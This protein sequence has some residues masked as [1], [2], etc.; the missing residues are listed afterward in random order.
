[1]EKN[2]FWHRQHLDRRPADP[3][4]VVAEL[5][6]I[7]T[8]YETTPP[9]ALAARLPDF[10]LKDFRESLS[11]G[12]LVW[13]SAMRGSKYVIH[14]SFANA[15]VSAFSPLAEELTW[16]GLESMG[17]RRDDVTRALDPVMKAL[18]AAPSPISSKQVEERVRAKGAKGALFILAAR[19]DVIRAGKRGSYT[20]RERWLPSSGPRP[21][22]AEATDLFIS[23]YLRSY[24][25]VTQEDAVWWTGLA[26]E[27]VKRSLRNT[28]RRDAQG[29]WTAIDGEDDAPPP[30]KELRLLPALDPLTMAWKERGRLVNPG[31]AD[32]IYSPQGGSYACVFWGGRAAGRWD[33]ARNVE[34]GSGQKIGR[35]KIL[36]EIERLEAAIKR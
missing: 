33:L 22:K 19:G 10:K 21:S 3:E 36:A 27:D 20:L 5:V 13:M 6:G 17:D 8:T 11:R 14:Q 12:R 32:L 28:G 2:S 29:Y 15:A 7:Q 24:G 31:D 25:P 4:I 16:R 1:M 9:L 30:E 26:T 35:S 18:E 34:M 23:A